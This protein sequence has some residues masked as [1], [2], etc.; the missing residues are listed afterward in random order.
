MSRLTYP[1]KDHPTPGTTREVAP[2]V[3]WLTMP[4]G[5]GLNHI[6]LYLLEDERGWVVVDTGLQTEETNKW[7]QKIF[8]T[9]LNGKP[10]VAVVCT[11]FHPD[12][13]GQALA[14]TEQFEC[15]FYMTRSE[16]FQARTFA[17]SGP[18]SHMSRMSTE[19][20]TRAGMDLSALEAMQ[21]GWNAKNRT[22]FRMPELPSG[23][24]RLRDGD[25]A[26]FGGRYW[27]VVVGDGHSPEH[28]CL[29][30]ESLNLMISGDQ[31]LPIITSNVSVHP[32]EPEAN[33]LNDWLQ[34]HERLAW[35][36]D[37]TFILPAHNLPFYGVSER[38]HELIDHHEE[39]MLAVEEY[40]TEKR[41]SVELLPIMF[42]RKLDGRQI[43]MAL[44]EAIAHLHLLMHRKRIRRILDDDGVYRYLAVDP[45]LQDRAHP[46]HHEPLLSGP[47]EV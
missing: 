25:Q 43:M 41:T 15:P 8:A 27:R 20:Y 19:F 5:G 21:E 10:V 2:G 37:E 30:C 6:N 44:G 16:Y 36:P 33:P 31:I 42:K 28:A 47:I 23:Y 22:V 24:R 9:E 26:K 13:I 40:C 1:F 11:H 38:L 17:N 7:W 18:S 35:I 45:N 32:T 14:I 46:A 4:M 29:Y 12:H 34:S 3:R 39:R